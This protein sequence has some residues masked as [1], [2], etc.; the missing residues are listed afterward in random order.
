MGFAFRR[1]KRAAFGNGWLKGQ[2]TVVVDAAQQAGNR[3]VG[4]SDAMSDLERTGSCP[5][6]TTP[7]PGVRALAR[8]RSR[9]RGGRDA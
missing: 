8:G 4:A 2:H 5:Q 9:S 1:R 6:P 3:H 7:E